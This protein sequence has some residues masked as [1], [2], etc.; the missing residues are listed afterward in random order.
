[1]YFA[2]LQPVLPARP[3]L[4]SSLNCH[5]SQHH[6]HYCALLN[7]SALDLELLKQMIAY[8][9]AWLWANARL[10]SKRDS[11]SSWQ[12]EICWATPTFD[13]KVG[14]HYADL[15]WP[16]SVYSASCPAARPSTAPLTQAVSYF[17]WH[18]WL[19]SCGSPCAPNTT[20]SP[21]P[22][23]AATITI[24][25]AETAAGALWSALIDHVCA[26][27]PWLFLRFASR[28]PAVHAPQWI[29][30]FSTTAL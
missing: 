3:R 5:C 12:S 7:H 29:A 8:C 10:I 9:H 18:R 15:Q 26:R 2:Q 21:A 4:W 24:C 22:S 16:T 25:I 28:I 17:H 11:A 19:T 30:L 6:R 14:P 27:P 20:S 23:A 13:C 1:M